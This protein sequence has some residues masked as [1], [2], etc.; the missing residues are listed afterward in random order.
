MLHSNK[1]ILNQQHLYFI[2]IDSSGNI[3]GHYHD[4][5]IDRLGYHY[6]N[7]IFMFTF[8]LNHIESI[9]KYRSLR[10]EMFTFIS[11]EDKELFSCCN[12]YS[13]NKIDSNTS[14][15]HEEIE[16]CF[17]GLTKKMFVQS[18]IFK[19]TKFKPK[20]VI[21]IR[22]GNNDNQIE[23]NEETIQ[24]QKENVKELYNQIPILEKSLQKKCFN[25]I[26]D[27]YNDG[28]DKESISKV[29][30]HKQVCF[31]TIDSSKDINGCYCSNEVQSE[32]KIDKD[33]D[34][35]FM[36]TIHN[37]KYKQQ[38]KEEYPY[39]Y[40]SVSNK[41]SSIFKCGYVEEN[42]DFKG[43]LFNMVMF[44]ERSCGKTSLMNRF[45]ENTFTDSHVC[46]V[47]KFITKDNIELE[48]EQVTLRIWEHCLYI[49]FIKI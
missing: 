39:K 30:G 47:D 10:N 42:K 2:T 17:D 9:K 44:G 4:S 40:L 12:V 35:M 13:V 49:K 5:L 15:V 48:G 32:M 19:T 38:N 45:V 3:F 25:V 14:S 31:I 8:S 22:M 20:R 7:K 21:V 27:S 18:T 28:K 1:K 33:D 37:S 34:S 24:K 46:I 23:I 26:Y 6:D 29:I 11:F 41:L 36:F 43:C 16:N